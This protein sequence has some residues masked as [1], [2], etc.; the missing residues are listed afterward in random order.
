VRTFYTVHRRIVRSS[1]LSDQEPRRANFR[2]GR[3]GD[4]GASLVLALVFLIVVSLITVSIAGLTAADLRLTSN[5]SSAQSMTAAADGAT[6][7]AIN[8]ARYNFVGATL[9]NPAPCTPAQLFNG[10]TVQAWCDTNWV[11]LA[12]VT[13]TVIISTCLSSVTSG[14]ACESSPLV[15]AIVV[16]DDYPTSSSFSS[17]VPDVT[18]NGSTCGSQME[19]QSWTYGV[20]PPVVTSITPA[21]AMCNTTNGTFTLT[22]VGFTPSSSVEF[23]STSGL[24][25]NVVLHAT[26]VVY[27]TSTLLTATPP[28]IPN[29]SGSYYVEVIGLTGANPIGS[30]SSTPVWTLLGTFVARRHRGVFN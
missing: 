13:R 22:G 10:Q 20:A 15:Q 4:D 6:E 17:C 23:V 11:P 24:A 18:T 14:V 5:F 16:F 19:L 26:N 12:A 25:N 8:Y 7:V 29:G 28:L 9:N 2:R 27:S 21:G 30:S 3:A 1:R